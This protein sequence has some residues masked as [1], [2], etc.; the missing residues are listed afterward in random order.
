MHLLKPEVLGKG[1]ERDQDDD[2]DND[3]GGVGARH[4]KLQMLLDRS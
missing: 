4:G 1:P 3:D 2:L